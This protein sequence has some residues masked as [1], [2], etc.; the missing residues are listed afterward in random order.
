MNFTEG[1]TLSGEKDCKRIE[2]WRIPF[3]AGAEGAK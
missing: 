1:I 3:R 2:L